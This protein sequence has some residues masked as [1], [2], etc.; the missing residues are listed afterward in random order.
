MTNMFAMNAKNILILNYTL[1]KMENVEILNQIVKE[2]IAQ[3]AQMIQ[4][5][6]VIHAIKIASLSMINA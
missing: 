4:K 3:Y 5:H 2:A 1:L 6:L